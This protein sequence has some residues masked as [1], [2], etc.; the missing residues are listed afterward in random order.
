MNTDVSTIKKLK[1]GMTLIHTRTPCKNTKTSSIYLYVRVGSINEEYNERGLSHFLEHLLFNGTSKRNSYTD[2]FRD[3]DEIGGEMNA[4][5][6]RDCTCFHITFPNKYMEEAID[7]L[8]DIIFH[9]HITTEK[10]E[11]EKLIVIEEENTI[12]TDAEDMTY[13]LLFNMIF[14]NQSIGLDPIG[15][16]KYVE[17]YDLSLVNKFKNKFYMPKN[18]IISV[19]SKYTDE[20]IFK[21]LKVFEKYHNNDKTI[22]EIPYK[23]VNQ[24]TPKIKILE[25]YSDQYVLGI[26]FKSLSIDDKRI[27][28]LNYLNA[29]IGRMYSSLLF[30][31]LRTKH[32]LVYSVGSDIDAYKHSG[33]FVIYCEMDRSK[34]YKVLERILIVLN[35]IVEKGISQK[36]YLK[37]KKS[38]DNS[39][40]NTDADSASLAEYKGKQYMY[41]GKILTDDELS[42]IYKKVKLGE[43]NELIKEIIDFR[44]INIVAQG[45][46]SESRI[47]KMIKSY[48]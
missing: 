46:L 25:E 37:V 15:G 22:E 1:N 48:L 19:S 12:R 18:M 7:I 38:I 36:N 6:Q 3:V 4:Y 31:D 28:A 26:G 40:I 11:R 14:G 24:D 10:I 9:S 5:T 8:E 47:M 35:N 41:K 39:L 13:K 29:V 34:F 23:F 2:I 32:N 45:R 33:I 43:I 17:R 21:Y 30:N 20:T 16:K 42:K 44:R 27:Y